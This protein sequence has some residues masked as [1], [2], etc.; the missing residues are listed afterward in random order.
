MTNQFHRGIAEHRIVSGS[1]TLPVVLPR[2]LVV[3]DDALARSEV[4]RVVNPSWS[5]TE[6][7]D[8]EGAIKYLWD[9]SF[10][11]IVLD[12]ML[13]HLS[14]YDV[15]RHLSMRRPELLARTII[16]TGVTD[17]SLAFIDPQSV[18]AIIKKPL[19]AQ[20]LLQT[21]ERLG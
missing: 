12:L 3:E 5:V 2:L 17:V 11:A 15:I 6:A 19:D 7:V 9:E 10:E 18:F 16:L 4:V 21:L 20:E 1:D 8:G 13:P 14:G